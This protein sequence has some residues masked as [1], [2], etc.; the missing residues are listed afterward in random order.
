M[1]KVIEIQPQYRCAARKLASQIYKN[2]EK[3]YC[4]ELATNLFSDY[5]EELGLTVDR[6][7]VKTGCIANVKFSDQGPRIAIIAELDAIKCRAHPASGLDGYA[8][9]C[10]HNLQVAAMYM[11]ASKLVEWKEAGGLCGSV[12]IIG[13]PSEEY[14]DLSVKEAM[15]ARGEIRYFGGK[16]EMVRKGYFNNVDIAMITHNMPTDYMG[17]NKVV[18]GSTNIGFCAKKVEFFGREAHAGLHPDDGINALHAM[19]QAINNINALR[20]TFPDK[21]GVRVH[22]IVTNGGET[23][24]VV[25][26][27]SSLEM[28]IRAR[29]LSCLNQV[30]E[31]INRCF[32]A[33]AQAI[34]CDVVITEMPGYLP[35]VLH[36][37]IADD[38]DRISRELLGEDSVGRGSMSGGA[39]DFGDLTQIMTTLKIA[40]GG[41][42]GSL[43]AKDFRLEDFDEACVLPAQVLGAMIR[44]LLENDGARAREILAENHPNLTVQAYLDLLSRYSRVLK[45]SYMTAE[46]PHGADD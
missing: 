5:L 37:N 11:L 1:Q 7:I 18:I 27:H 16:Q 14:I 3:G 21:E 4:E 9:C 35:G 40:T 23:V 33:A 15:Q 24:N 19:V 25:P 20:D 22:Y 44:E 39:S 29:S 46:V 30:S 34:G 42:S 31:R 26:G 41:I 45:Y 6:N 43:H 38:C 32:Q 12:D 8:H 36:S 10:G 17:R 28:H 2:P 13:V